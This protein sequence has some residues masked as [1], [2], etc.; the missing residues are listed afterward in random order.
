MA[1]VQEKK[2]EKPE[3]SKESKNKKDLGITADK[4]ELSEW[5]TQIL[6]KAELI[7]YTTVSGCYILRP[8]LYAIWEK[9]Q[10][11]F[12][13][14]I[15]ED[16]VK[17]C[18]FPLFIPESLLLKEKE[19]VQGFS[20]EVAW[21]TQ[22]GDTPLNEK[23]A[24]RPTSESIIYPAYAKWIRSYRDLPLRLNQWCNV[25][26]WEFKHP[27]PLLRSREFLW[28]EGHTAFATKQ[29]A[30]AE[31]YKIQDL[32]AR[33]FREMYALPI[34]KGRKTHKEKFAGADYTLTTEAFLPSG[35]SAQAATSHHL[36]Q[37][38]SKAFNIKFKTPQQKEEFVWQNSWGLSTRS[39]GI[40]IMMHSDNKG[41]IL[42]PKVASPQ[43]IIIPIFSDEKEKAI[44]LKEAEKI[45][46]FLSEIEIEID[47]RDQTPGF[48]FNDAE[49]K[50]IP[51]R[52][53]LGPRDIKENQ[54][55]IARRDSSS[56]ETV[57]IKD[58][59]S[60]LQQ[61]LEDIQNNLYK[62]AEFHLKSS[63]IKTKNIQEARQAIQS[64]KLVKTAWCGSQE[65]EDNIK[66]ETG[67]A[68]VIC[69]LESEKVSSQ[70][71]CVNC[72]QSAQHIIYIAKSY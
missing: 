24:I 32:Y 10:N 47:S 44:I 59:K 1:K 13:G 26:R 15:K 18:Y 2:A 29:E 19:H 64:K 46:G 63:T 12:D 23:L 56:K 5:Y 72:Q 51:I 49:L 37:N 21:V 25:V 31:A 69:I 67:G 16:G 34:I 66:A 7:E 8:R 14:K 41:L 52:I 55:V 3:K 71:K 20:P 27:L 38:F 36:G 60:K 70:D 65:C 58:L 42:P 57:K 33:T 45:K 43:A 35:K 6:Q 9:V 28:Q 48:K 22:T 39:I 11:Y 17:N 54:V 68:K 50:G 40:A 53:E 30:D 61:T 4:D 62:K